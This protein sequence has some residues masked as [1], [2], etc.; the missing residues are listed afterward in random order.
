MV[1]TGSSAQRIHADAIV[2]DAT[3]PLLH[4]E[5]LEWWIEG[6][7]TAAAPSVGGFEPAGPTMR[8]LGYWLRRIAIDPRLRLVRSARDV[9]EVKAEGQ[10][11]II[12]HF[13]GTEPIENDL[14]LVDA[15][16]E[17]GVG[18]IQLA[19]NVKNRVGDGCEE[20]TDCGL[21]NF[22]VEFI[23]RCNEAKV[24]VDC[25]HTG[26]QTTM[27]AMEISTAPVVFSHSNPKAVKKSQRTITD[28]Q[29]QAAAAT[30]GLVGMV[31][32]PAF[33][34]DAAHPTL[35]EFIDHIDHVV[36]LVGI[37]YVGLGID[38][39]HGQAGVVDDETAENM[40]RELVSSGRWQVENYPPPPYHYPEGIDTPRT[41]PNLTARLLE[42]GYDEASVK[43]I[44]GENWL[45]VYRTVWGE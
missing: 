16:K 13:Q 33:V 19:Y 39:F 42:R 31:G 18:I 14:N 40:Y 44:L 26:Y 24:I 15:Y 9:E 34:S 29:I 32:F 11:G 17:L 35:D 3:C 5:Y 37:E 23:K 10:F 30:G 12:L 7:V 8:S 21:S 43:K 6:G 36:N 20:R 4:G 38:Y 25:T 41:L 27:E 28:E 1:Q 22:G 45:R 2:I